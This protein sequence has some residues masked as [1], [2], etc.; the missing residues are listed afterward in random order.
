[1]KSKM[2]FNFMKSFIKP[3]P[4]L[5]RLSFFGV[6]GPAN[7]TARAWAAAG[8]TMTRESLAPLLPERVL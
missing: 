3:A 4:D 8:V 6:D 1:M 2:D 7:P 5:S